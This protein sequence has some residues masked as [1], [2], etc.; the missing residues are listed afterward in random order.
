MTVGPTAS[1]HAGD[2]E[3]TWRPWLYGGNKTRVTIFPYNDDGWLPVPFQGRRPA[4]YPFWVSSNGPDC[5]AG[6]A[7]SWSCVAVQGLIE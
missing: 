1:Q 2:L 6:H 5:R 4:A 7:P 3:C